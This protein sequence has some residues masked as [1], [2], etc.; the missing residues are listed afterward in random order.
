MNRPHYFDPQELAP[1]AYTRR[2]YVSVGDVFKLL[3]R[4]ALL[5]F[6]TTAVAV[7]FATA[8]Y[9]VTA[10]T[11][12]AQAQLLLDPKIPQIFREASDLGLAVDTGQIETHMVVLK[13]RAIASAVVNR[14]ELWNDPDF[15]KQAGSGLLSRIMGKP[16]VKGDPKQIATDL[17][18]RRL[19]IERE[20]I[21][22]VINVFCTSGSANRAAQLA[23]ET[24]QAY[25]QY[26]I[27]ARAQSAR[28]ASDWLEQRLRQ[29]RLEMNAAAKRAQNFR[30]S[31]E[32][33]TLEELQLSAETYR[34]TYQDFY[35]AFTEAVQRESYPVF[36]VRI[37]SR[38]V[39]PLS[40]YSPSAVMVF[41]AAVLI[42]LAA[43]LLLA[44]IRESR[45]P[46]DHLAR[47]G[48]AGKAS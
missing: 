38:A 15:Q 19:R 18:L 35:S 25:I 48:S 16:S 12:R 21:S 41:G 24:A 3:S 46:T 40:R 26:L 45:R 7:I 1:Q 29:L 44:I 14:L 4:N 2:E 23:N 31:S 11:Y 32:S 17:L 22:Q 27:D 43:G 47:A 5:M 28:S 42:G 33:A 34:K 20:G 30:A 39:P 37:V 13:S 9:T 8:Y 6:V 36:T 10:P